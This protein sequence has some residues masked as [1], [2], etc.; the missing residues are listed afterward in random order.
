LTRRFCVARILEANRASSRRLSHA[1]RF[2]LQADAWVPGITL[3]W[4]QV[5]LAAENHAITDLNSGVSLTRVVSPIPG[6]DPGAGFHTTQ[7]TRI[8]LAR[9]SSVQARAALNDLCVT[10]YNPVYFFLL[11][12]VPAI[13]AARDLTQEFFSRILEGHRLDGATPA[14]GRFRSYLLGAVKHMLAD[15]R[16]AAGR[17]KRGGGAQTQS[18]DQ[19]ADRPI[20]VADPRAI[21]PD[22][23]FDRQWAMA[24]LKRVLDQ[25]GQEKAQQGKAEQWQILEPWLNSE[26]AGASLEAAAVQLSMELGAVRMAIHRLRRRFRELVKLEIAATVDD[27]A[28]VKEEMNYLIRVLAQGNGK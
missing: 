3:A 24:V 28:D 15:M 21:D 4:R 6:S 22:L 10:Y 12:Q 19:D 11:R 17:L 20:D 7:W 8:L 27:P 26:P 16:Q 25:L 5:A 18:L 13:E 14:K 23:E 1:G 9:G 2:R